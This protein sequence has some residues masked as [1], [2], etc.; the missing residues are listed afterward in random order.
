MIKSILLLLTVLTSYGVDMLNVAE[1]NNNVIAIKREINANFT[2]V[3][4]STCRD[5]SFEGNPEKITKKP[6]QVGNLSKIDNN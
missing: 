1:G 6:H 3:K 4:V 5:I 2:R